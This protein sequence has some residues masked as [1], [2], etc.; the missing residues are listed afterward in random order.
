MVSTAWKTNSI[1]V[2]KSSIVNWGYQDNFKPV[3]FFLQKDF[4]RTK[5]FTSKNE[6]TK[7]KISE[8]K[9]TKT[10]TSKRVKVACFAFW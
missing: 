1:N 6:L 8:Q 7:T 4:A 9:T 5:T 3:Y 10:T 2:K